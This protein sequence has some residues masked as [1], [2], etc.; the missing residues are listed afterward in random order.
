MSIKQKIAIVPGSFDPITLGHLDII[1]RAASE[2]DSV[3]VAVMINQEKRYMF[4]MEQRKRFAEAAVRDLSNVHVISSEG[5]LWQLA[6]ELRACALVKGYR[7]EADL[8]YEQSMA[9]YN[10]THYPE[11]ETVLLPANI[12]YEQIS[13]TKVRAILTERGD[14]SPWLPQAVIDEIYRFLPR[15]L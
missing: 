4:T 10:K 6:K 11:A 14:L 13:S 5:M 1:Q 12:E 15:S 3:Y 2:Y 8:A 9:N 7:N